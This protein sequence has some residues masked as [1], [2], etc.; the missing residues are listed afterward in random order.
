MTKILVT[1]LEMFHGF[2]IFASPTLGERSVL[3]P[4][5][6]GC[7]PLNRYAFRITQVRTG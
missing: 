2:Y 4:V 6:V 1:E 7:V 5:Y 3:D